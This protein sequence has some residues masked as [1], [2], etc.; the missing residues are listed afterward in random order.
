[1]RLKGLLGIEVVWFPYPYHI[2][3][4]AKVH[5]LARDVNF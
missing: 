4:F 3:T 2:V 1:M 5:I